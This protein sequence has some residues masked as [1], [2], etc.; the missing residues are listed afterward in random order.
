MVMIV[1]IIVTIAGS[2]SGTFN[3]TITG[4]Q[5]PHSRTPGR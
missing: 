4:G 1:I 2:N 5:N 3:I